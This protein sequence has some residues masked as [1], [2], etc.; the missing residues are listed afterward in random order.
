MGFDGTSPPGFTITNV[1]TH[2]RATVNLSAGERLR[3]LPEA[4]VDATGTPARGASPEAA[5]FG[6][7]EGHAHI[8]AFEFL[9]GDWHCGRPWSPFGAPYALPASCAAD[10]Q[11]TNGAFES[12][13]DFGGPTAPSECTGWP[14]LQGLAKPDRAR[15]GGRLLHGDRARVEGRA[16]AD[17]DQPRRQRGAVLADDDAP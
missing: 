7:V 9:G 4:S 1:A 11:G 13:I 6:T 12:F 2:M 17:G 16:A 10:E 15:R 5:V 14:T 3:P 8:T